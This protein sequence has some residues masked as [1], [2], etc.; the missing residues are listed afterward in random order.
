ML[1]TECCE[2]YGA[3]VSSDNARLASVYIGLGSNLGDRARHLQCGV[4]TLRRLGEV[5]S[6]SNVYESD[7]LGVNEPQ[8]AYLNMVASLA[9]GLSPASLLDELLDAERQ[10]GRE[11]QVRNAPR[12]LDL[13]LLAYGDLV[14][15][16][17]ELTV[18]HPRLHERAFVLMPLMEVAPGFRHPIT[19]K[20]L[21]EMMAEVTSQGIKMVG[22]LEGLVGASEMAA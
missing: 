11:R 18:P 21:L 17:P 19:N 8:P 12:T 14:L 16:R 4:E 2:R 5:I 15:R 3:R 9:T 13:D 7:P 20:T 22:A 6:V 1:A 10:H